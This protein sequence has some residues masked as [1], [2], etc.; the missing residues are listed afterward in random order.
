MRI[1]TITGA[2]PQFIKLAPLSRTI[3]CRHT[4]VLIHTGQHYDPEMSD[5]F[6]KDLDIPRPDYNL[7]VGSGSPGVQ[8]AEMLR[9]IERVLISDRPDAVIVFGDTNSTL[10]GSLAAVKLGIPSVHVEAGLRSF[11]RMMPEEINRIV[12]DHSSDILLV[13]TQTAMDNLHNEGLASRSF[14]TG[15]I[16]VDTLTENI[17]R[18]MRH[19]RI[20]DSMKIEPGSY[21]VLTLHRP[22]NVDN[23][24]VLY[25]ILNEVSKIDVT[26]I[27]PVH[28]RTKKM[29]REHDIR[30]NSNIMITDPAGY[31]DFITLM[32]NSR[33]ILTDSGGIQKEAY[34]LKK[35]CVTIRSETEWTETVHAGWNLL[36]QYDDERFSL[37]IR[38]FS[39]PDEH[40]DLFGR[41]V[42]E[43]ML[44][45]IEENIESK[46]DV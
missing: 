46:R 44:S 4:E 14:L 18:A 1:A 35:P 42:S 7:N 26:V 38:E 34:I 27:F 30:I 12:T 21:Y 36:V 3:R 37:K 8:T 15:D 41:N 10:A 25:R 6:F 33:M 40:P 45:V 23:H 5:N 31:L 28:P 24:T 17:E 43:K 39:P 13:P 22:Y 20:I 16:M 29:I 11:N 2:R 32:N 19:S 9:K